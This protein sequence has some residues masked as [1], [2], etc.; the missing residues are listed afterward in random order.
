MMIFDS[1][2]IV[3]IPTQLILNKRFR[4]WIM[5]IVC[6]LF[7]SA[8]IKTTMSVARNKTSCSNK[9]GRD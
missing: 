7:G 6:R 8:N 4:S 3:E 2:S 1:T 9:M 5:T